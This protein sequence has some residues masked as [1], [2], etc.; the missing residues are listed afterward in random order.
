MTQKRQ[1][2]GTPASPGGQAMIARYPALAAL[3]E[4][5]MARD[6]IDA[7]RAIQAAASVF[8]VEVGSLGNLLLAAQAADVIDDGDRIARVRTL[9]MVPSE[10]G[11]DTQAQHASRR[12]G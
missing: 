3:A 8:A 9:S 12:L 10:V 2:V 1:L 7:A 11:D 5:R 6:A 4:E